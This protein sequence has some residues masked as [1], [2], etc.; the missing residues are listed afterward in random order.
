MLWAVA[1]TQ[2]SVAAAAP[3]T[4]GN[5]Q[6]AFY[7]NPTNIGAFDPSVLTSPAAFTQQ[8]PVIAFNPPIGAVPCSNITSADVNLFSRPLTDVVPNPDG[9]CSLAP[10][11]GTLRLV[12]ARDGTCRG[13]TGAG[14]AST[15]D[16]SWA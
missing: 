5:V 15:R 9:T 10:A 14:A 8:F 11:M 2:S 7:T 4:I 6:G 12:T 3:V 1:V 13:A 16:K